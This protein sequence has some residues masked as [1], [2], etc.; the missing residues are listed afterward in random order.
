MIGKVYLPVKVG[1]SSPQPTEWSQEY[2]ES[3]YNS[4]QRPSE[5]LALPTLTEGEQKVVGL[6]AIYP[7]NSTFVAF[8]CAGN[9]TVNWG[10]GTTEDFDA[11]TIAQRNIQYES[12]SGQTETFRGYKQ[13]II[14]ITPQTVLTLIL[15][16][17][18]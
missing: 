10:D 14:T 18:Q 17:T 7:S 16:I 8:T 13:C 11:S 12:F 4:Y 2:Y 9:Y 5:W 15:I 6:Y 3:V 1:G